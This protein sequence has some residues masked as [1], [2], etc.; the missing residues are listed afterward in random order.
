MRHIK[1]FESFSQ[2]NEEE[3]FGKIFGGGEISKAV[4]NFT[5][6]NK[7]KF[8]ELKVAEKVGGD[9]LRKVQSELMKKL[10]EYKP[11]LRKILKDQ[12]DF[13][14]AIREISDKIKNINPDDK[15]TT[16]QKIS[17]GASGGFPGGK[18]K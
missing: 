3:I 4:S 11:K 13:N 6:D 17:G 10:Q 14:T 8:D 7:E 18:S 9:R 16:F 5:L 1:T 2:V 12:S 15:R